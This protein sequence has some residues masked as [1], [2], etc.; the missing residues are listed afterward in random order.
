MESHYTRAHLTC[1]FIDGSKPVAEIC[2]GYVDYRKRSNKLFENYVIFDR[3]FN[4]KFFSFIFHT[5]KK[6][7]KLCLAIN[8]TIEKDKNKSHQKDLTQKEEE[9]NGQQQK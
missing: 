2:R 6:Q 5:T 8:N 7:C 9:E 3:I 4:T 1:H